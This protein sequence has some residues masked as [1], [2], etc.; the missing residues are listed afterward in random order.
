MQCSDLLVEYCST[1]MLVRDAA[2]K[3]ETM[4]GHVIS[5]PQSSRACSI[6][7]CLATIPVSLQIAYIATKHTLR[8]LPITLW[9]APGLPSTHGT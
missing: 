4:T 2:L 9:S 1:L 8:A 3:E 6:L 7:T 5:G